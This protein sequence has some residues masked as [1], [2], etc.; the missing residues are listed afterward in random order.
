MSLAKRFAVFQGNHVVCFLDFKVERCFACV[1][2][3]ARCSHDFDFVH[4]CRHGGSLRP[5]FFA[6]FLEHERYFS[7][8]HYVELFFGDFNGVSVMSLAKHFA[9]F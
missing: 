8:A 2:V 5:R 3:H 9:F 7:G 1:V 4:A 6:V